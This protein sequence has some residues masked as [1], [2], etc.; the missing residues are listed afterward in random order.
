MSQ[1]GHQLVF[2]LAKW[3][4]KEIITQNLK[5]NVVDDMVEKIAE[6]KSIHWEEK[7]EEFE[8]AGNMYDVVKK[9]VI[10]HQTIY[11][12][13]NDKNETGLIQ[14]YNH[15]MQ[16][17]NSN[18]QGKQGVKS[19][20]KFT[21]I[22]CDFPTQKVAMKKSYCAENKLVVN[23]CDTLYRSLLVEGPPPKIFA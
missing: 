10:N 2:A 18:T 13:I 6:N 20:L 11:Y 4:A 21:Q 12:C 16:N 15:W 8:L 3:N 19:I 5:L 17:E 14:V 9:E 22:E 23:D 7:N 1:I